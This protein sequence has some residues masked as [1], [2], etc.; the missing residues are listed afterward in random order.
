M[1]DVCTI[2]KEVPGALD[3]DTGK[4]TMTIEPVYSGPCR[5]RAS[6]VQAQDAEVAGRYLVTQAATL[7]LP[8]EGSGAVSKGHVVRIT[9]SATDPALVGKKVTIDGPFASS[10]ATARRF[11][12]TVTT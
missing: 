5:F 12:V 3:E 4:R 8:M 7:S 1:T 6:A 10:D 2:G 9:S 11:P